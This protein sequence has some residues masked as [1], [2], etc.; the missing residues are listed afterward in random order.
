MKLS[1]K[2]LTLMSFFTDNNFIIH[3]HQTRKT[4]N[5]IAEIYNDI[6]NAYKYIIGLKKTYGNN[7]Y[8]ISL[9]PIKSATQ[10]KKPKNF[11]SSSFPEEVRNHIDK[12]ASYELTYAFSLF[13]KEIRLFFILE[14]PKTYHKI[15]LILF[16][17]QDKEI[18]F[19]P[20]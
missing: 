1:K 3:S 7:L 4:Q 13:E 8:N 19:N 9:K 5:T 20:Y 12:L 11:A 6:L 17:V 10:I 14:N 18:P 16:K 2:S 15:L